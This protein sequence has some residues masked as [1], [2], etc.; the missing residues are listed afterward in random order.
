MES[1]WRGLVGGRAGGRPFGPNHSDTIEIYGFPRTLV[2]GACP[3]SAGF[4]GD[5]AGERQ[6]CTDPFGYPI[7]IYGFPRLHA[8]SRVRAVSLAGKNERLIFFHNVGHHWILKYSERSSSSSTDHYPIKRG[9]HAKEGESLFLHMTQTLSDTFGPGD[10]LCIR[11]ILYLPSLMEKNY[12][13]LS[14]WTIN[15]N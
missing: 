1:S 13:I 12:I 15:Y 5:R 8:A 10:G 4:G 9:I 6:F 14:N 2:F 3:F 11:K 7:E